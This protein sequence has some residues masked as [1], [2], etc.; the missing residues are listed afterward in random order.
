MRNDLRV[1]LE[2]LQKL[3]QIIA[4]EIKE[5]VEITSRRLE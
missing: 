4:D 5:L 1:T 2:R 3:E